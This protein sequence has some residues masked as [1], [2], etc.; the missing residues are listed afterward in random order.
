MSFCRCAWLCIERKRQKE[1]GIETRHSWERQAV[2]LSGH[3]Q[4]P[5]GGG[6]GSGSG[7]AF[8]VSMHGPGS[9]ST[10]RRHP[11]CRRPDL[12][13]ARQQSPPP[14]KELEV[15]RGAQ[16]LKDWV[17]F[18]KTHGLPLKHFLAGTENSE[19]T[20]NP[21]LSEQALAAWSKDP[22]YSQRSQGLASFLPPSLV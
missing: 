8:T 3:S 19:D 5:F 4:M 1:H 13:H 11:E 18:T 7:G 16:P 22:N 6:R 15:C 12:D 17:G 14:R 2:P 9:I 20:L 21:H 10:A